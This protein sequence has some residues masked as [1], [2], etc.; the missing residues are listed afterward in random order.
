M[1]RITRIKPI[2]TA[3]ARPGAG[4]TEALLTKLPPLLHEGKRVILALPTLVLSNDITERASHMGIPVRTIDQRTEELVIPEL[5]LAFGKSV[6]R[7]LF[8]LKR[9]F[10]VCRTPCCMAGCS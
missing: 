6:N 1:T 9:L 10:G 3:I 2:Y 4:K 5:K 8:V 7:S